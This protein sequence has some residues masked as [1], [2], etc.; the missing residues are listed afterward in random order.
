M[1]DLTQAGFAFAGGHTP[2][3]GCRFNQQHA[4][5]R[6]GFAQVLLRHANGATAHTGHVT[7]NAFAA[8]VVMGR[9]IHHTDFFPIHFQFFGN[10]HGCRG[11]TALSHLGA[12]IANDHCVVCMDVD[13]GIDFGGLGVLC[14]GRPDKSQAHGRSGAT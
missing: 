8:Q 11:A 5:G 10:Q 7:V 9:H 4:C 13:P 14:V 6:A 3:F 1:H 2:A 12:C